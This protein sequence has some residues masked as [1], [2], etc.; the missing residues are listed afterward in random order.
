MMVDR[1]ALAKR[2]SEGTISFTSSLVEQALYSDA[3]R[4][5][6]MQQLEKRLLAEVR[7]K[8][9]PRRPTRVLEDKLDMIRA[10][11]ASTERAL[12]RRLISRKVLHRLLMSFLGNAVLGQDDS[13]Q[14]ARRAFAERNGLREPPTLMVISPTKACNLRCIGCYANSGPEVE[15]L[16]WD[17]FD[18]IITEAKSL[19]GMRFFTISGGEPLVYRSQGKGLLDMVAKHSDCFFQMYTNG[20]LISR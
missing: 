13:A 11:L 8:A 15:Q 9:D 10:L 20:T 1:N 18:R 14:R 4:P 5:L 2:L 17:V 3:A 6:V 12:Q 7:S 16:E 19:W